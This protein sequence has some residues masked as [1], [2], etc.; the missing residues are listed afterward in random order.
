MIMDLP[1]DL[2]PDM[3]SEEEDKFELAEESAESCDGPDQ[4]SKSAGLMEQP[5]L[6]WLAEWQDEVERGEPQ[7]Q[8]VNPEAPTATH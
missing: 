6:D 5:Q 1:L 7:L 3:N 8:W 4:G 2:S